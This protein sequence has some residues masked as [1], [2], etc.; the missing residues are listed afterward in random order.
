ML[1]FKRE[2]MKIPFT[3]KAVGGEAQP[4]RSKRNRQDNSQ[5]LSWAL[6]LAFGFVALFIGLIGGLDSPILLTMAGGAV[7]AILLFF[8]MKLQ[9][10]LFVLIL[11]TFLIQGSAMYFLGLRSATWV[12]VGFSVLYFFKALL[13][14]IGR[15]KE[16]VKMPAD[17]RCGFLAVCALLYVCCF[18]MSIV[19]N[20]VSIGQT[21]AA[22]KAGLPM[23]SVLFAFFCFRWERIQL[24]KVW[25][26][27]ILIMLL[28]LPVVVYQHFFIA[29]ART[30]DSIVGTFGGT[31]QG[32]GNSA[33]LVFFVITV[34]TYCFARWD[35]K[36]MPGMRLILICLIGVAIIFLGEVKAAF[37]WVPLT[38]FWVLRKRIFKNI[39][40][41][42][43]YCMLIVVFM[44]VTY[45]V[46]NALYWGKVVDKGHTISEK[47]NAGGGYFFDPTNVNYVT[48]EVS[49]GASIALWVNDHTATIPKR[50]VGFGPGSSKLTGLLAAGD[51]ARR[52]A[53]LH[54]DATTLAILLWDVGL[55]GT[56]A[57]ILMLFAGIFAGWRFISKKRGTPVERAMMEACVTM[58]ALYLTMLIYNRA[59]MD[60]PTAQLLFML[61]LG[62]VVQLCRF[63]TPAGAAEAMSDAPLMAACGRTIFR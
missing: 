44:G 39:F 4:W 13:E 18:F 23:F 6:T 28:Q 54:I 36:L 17:A 47:L 52:Y 20:R 33:I 45:T 11:I 12:A 8:L 9:N 35:H 19:F 51:V 37:I 50:L 31:Q 7:F 55:L 57:Y 48:G 3:A 41:L 27:F 15:R 53:P 16:M 14:L 38:S 58:L 60:E 59:L 30:F 61:T 2:N 5:R 22:I 29:T 43:T 32:G 34:M 40:A 56:A 46:Y 1:Q 10:M 49:R 26:F 21:A 25:Q 63:S 42:F 24:E 62:T